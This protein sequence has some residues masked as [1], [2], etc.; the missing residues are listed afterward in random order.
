MY[1]ALCTTPSLWNKQVSDMMKV[2]TL[3][4]DPAVHALDPR[5]STHAQVLQPYVSQFHSWKTGVPTDAA[6]APSSLP[7][8]GPEASVPKEQT[9]STPATESTSVQANPTS[10]QNQTCL[11]YTSDAADE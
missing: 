10:T 3:P 5:S 6:A 11:L 1:G 8:P 9:N 2:D 7:A 4:R